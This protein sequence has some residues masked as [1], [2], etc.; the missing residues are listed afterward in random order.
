M[1][2]EQNAIATPTTPEVFTDWYAT[3]AEREGNARFVFI[4]ASY[5]IVIAKKILRQAPRPSQPLEVAPWAK[6]FIGKVPAKGESPTSFLI[7]GVQVRWDDV[8]AAIDNPPTIEA[9]VIVSYFG[10]PKGKA[11]SFMVIDGW[12]RLARAH[13]TGVAT[14]PCV[15]LTVEETRRIARGLPKGT[16]P[17][18][19]KSA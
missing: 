18:R 8:W 1:N 5:D 4:N 19:K 11:P 17:P 12:H 7:F 10:P 16:L 15:L 13:A 14:V 6:E 9:P 2:T 3:K